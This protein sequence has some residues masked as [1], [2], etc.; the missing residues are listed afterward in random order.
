MQQQDQ[1]RALVD[2]AALGLYL[3]RILIHI[4]LWSFRLPDAPRLRE[5]R[6]LP[7]Y[8]PG[9]PLPEIREFAVDEPRHGIPVAVRL[10]HYPYGESRRSRAIEANPDACEAIKTPIL[11]IHGY[12]AS[13]TTFAHHAVRPNVASSLWRRGRD[14]W[15]ADLRTSAG[16]PHAKSPWT[17]EEVGLADIPMAVHQVCALTGAAQIDV[18]AHCMGS[19]MLGMALL[20]PETSHEHFAPLRRELPDRIRHLVMSQ[21]APAR[22]LHAGQRVPRLRH[23]VPEALSPAA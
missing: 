12:S 11:L 10:T 4:H 9:L 5:I 19:A 8:V 1:A 16:M 22:D 13:G 6:R 20:G 15:I 7:G 21:V 23:A 17:F 3:L 14:V 2:V 18:F